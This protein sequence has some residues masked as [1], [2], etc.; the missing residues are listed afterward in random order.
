MKQLINWSGIGLAAL[1]LIGCQT[2]KTVPTSVACSVGDVMQQTTLWFGLSKPN[3]QL[4]SPQQW[5]QFVDQYITPAFREGL[6]VIDAQGQW[7]GHDGRIAYE[8]SRGVMLIYSADDDKSRAIE[9]IRAY[10]KQRF[11]QESVMRIDNSV[12]VDF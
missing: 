5:Q 11:A 3:G 9:Q 7:L 10:Y 4:I 1:L 12:C 8:K 6:S 2:Q